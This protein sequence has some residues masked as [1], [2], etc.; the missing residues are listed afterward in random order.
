MSRERH[1]VQVGI[2]SGNIQGCASINYPDIFTRIEDP[3]I[4]QFIQTT[5]QAN[6]DD[7]EEKQNTDDTNDEYE[8]VFHE[9]EYGYEDG[10]S[11]ITIG[12]PEVNKPC[13]FPF[14]WNGKI[15]N[16]CTNG[17]ARKR[18]C[19]QIV[20]KGSSINHV[21]KILGIFDPSW[22]LL[23]NKSYLLIWLAPFPL[24]CPRGL[25]MTP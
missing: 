11:C 4:F 6:P 13:R 17:E 2:T 20:N 22:L 8:Y 24:N 19:D 12:G 23:P 16:S 7:D 1:F 15:F 21:V 5:M 3:E 14:K 25:C 18:Q 9:Y 10:D